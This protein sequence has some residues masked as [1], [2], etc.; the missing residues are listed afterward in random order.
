MTDKR[1]PIAH[2]SEDGRTHYL[3][4]HLTETAKQASTFAEAFNSAVWARAAGLL[5][6]LGKAHPDF[7][8]YLC[9]TRSLEASE[10][11]EQSAGTRPNHSGAG[12]ILAYEKF[13]NIIGKT[14]AYIIAGHH[15]GL[16]DWFGGRDSL[17]YRLEN[18]RSV[19]ATIRKYVKT[20]TEMFPAMLQ[21]PA[22]VMQCHNQDA[23]AY[24]LWVR[25]VFSCLVDADFLDTEA[26]MDNNRHALRPSFP[27]LIELKSHF[28]RQMGIMTADA[29]D[30]FVNRIRAEILIACRT[31][32]VQSPGIFSLTVP[33]GG[34]KTLSGAAFAL[35]HAIQHNKSRVIYVIPYTS[36]IE[37]TAEVLRKFFGS[38][39]VIE[40]HSNI[41]PERVM[42]LP[43]LA[44]AFENWDA[45]VIVTTSVQFF[46]SLY[47][48]KPGRC[49][50]LH[51]IVNSVIILDEAQLLPPELLY[52]CV[53]A[54]NR[55]ISDYGVTVVLSTATQPALN[56]CQAPRE[57][58]PN[59]DSLYNLLKRTNIIFPDDINRPRDWPDLAA[60]LAGHDQV[61]CIVN[62]RQDCHELWKEM[63]EGT[64][65]LS[66]LMCG[67]HRS[68]IIADIKNRIHYGGSCR[69]ISTQLVEAGVDID[70]PVVYRA[71]AGLDSVN[72]AAGR[73]NR[74]GKNPGSGKVYVFIAPKPAPPGLLRKGE[75]ASREL[76]SFSDFKPDAPV[77][78]QRYFEKYYASI[79]DNGENWWRDN[80]VKNVNPDGNVQFR[81]A[82]KEFRLIKDLSTPII[83]SYGNND[84]T[85]KKLRFAGP[86]REVMRALQRYAV[87]VKP[88]VANSLLAEGRVEEIH[89]GILVQA[90]SKLYRSDIGLDIYREAYDPED[91]CI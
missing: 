35:D 28:D 66:A 85:I 14:L 36:I 61:L 73:C 68:R 43:S 39:N 32:A 22:F 21:A 10:Y 58:I 19:A 3:N 77:S 83:V 2:I 89:D 49:R 48:A 42:E 38:A 30:T 27:S 63:P 54:L 55:L 31:A 90:D 81:T 9:K 59:Q 88:S 52:P 16:P 78:F 46:E 76:A 20:V 34:G 41:A 80:L 71:L 8:A 25:M 51:N 86:S 4:E 23:I 44:L 74:E 50:K 33:T 40:H 53:E 69:V 18:E 29:S 91:L 84:K 79:N 24:H 1:E 75:D 56:L 26:F 65:H 60:E 70:F 15:A 67:E 17:S 72:Q 82:G 45:P 6:D 11:D 13:P 87:S 47:A 62:T 12:G 37:Q 64:I 5:H 7:Q 57:I